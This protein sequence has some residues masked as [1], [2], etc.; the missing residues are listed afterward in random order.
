MANNRSIVQDLA[1]AKHLAALN[2]LCSQILEYENEHRTRH[3]AVAAVAEVP[4]VPHKTYTHAATTTP[5]ARAD[6]PRPGMTWCNMHEWCRHT[7]ADCR[8][9]TKRSASAPDNRPKQRRTN[10]KQSAASSAS[11]TDW[12][13]NYKSINNV[14]KTK[15]AAAESNEETGSVGAVSSTTTADAKPVPRPVILDVTSL[16]PDNASAPSKVMVDSGAERT[17]LNQNI[18]KKVGVVITPTSTQ[19][20][21][22]SGEPLTVF[23][24]GKIHI[25]LPGDNKPLPLDVLV[26]DDA[27]CD[28]IW[29]ADQMW[30]RPDGRNVSM[31]ANV[32]QPLVTR[33]G[34]LSYTINATTIHSAATVPGPHKAEQFAADAERRQN[35]LDAENNIKLSVLPPQ[36]RSSYASSIANP[37]P[38]R[39]LRGADLE[40]HK[41]V[42]ANIDPSFSTRYKRV[43]CTILQLLLFYG[44][45]FGGLKAADS[46]AFP[47]PSL[48]TPMTFALIPG[49]DPAA[50]LSGNPVRLSMADESVMN[51]K[52]EEMIDLGLLRV[53]H[54]AVALAR[55]FVVRV[56]GKE[57]RIVVAMQ[58]VNEATWPNLY[59]LPLITDLQQH[60]AKYLYK[61]TFDVW[62]AF[63]QVLL[64]DASVPLT[65][66][67]FGK[68]VCEF[69][70]VP[71]GLRQSPGHLQRVLSAALNT[72][73][74]SYS[75]RVYI[76]DIIVGAKTPEALQDALEY[77]FKKCKQY[78]IT[79]SARKSVIGAEKTVI[80]GALVG[81]GQVW[82]LTDHLTAVLNYG[83]PET[84][85]QM[86]MFLGKL[87]Q[88][89]VYIT[90]PD[91]PSMQ[92]LHSLAANNVPG[93]QKIKWTDETKKA[94]ER[95]RQMVTNT[96]STVPFNPQRQLFL[97]IDA[98]DYGFGAVLAHLDHQRQAFEVIDVVSGKWSNAQHKYTTP[99]KEITAIRC[100]S[101]RFH[102]LMYG[103]R[104][105]V[106]CDNASV[107]HIIAN[108]T[109]S[110]VPRI[111]NTAAELT[112]YYLV[113]VHLPGSL[114]AAA[115]AL[116]R[117]PAFF[118]RDATDVEEE[119]DAETASAP[120]RVESY[121][122]GAICAV[123]A[124][125]DPTGDVLAATA[126][127]GQRA[128]SSSSRT[129]IQALVERQNTDPSLALWR[130]VANGAT[131]KLYQE[132]TAVWRQAL[133]LKPQFDPAF[134]NALFVYVDGARRLVIPD[135]YREYVT[136]SV[137]GDAHLCAADTVLLARRHYY[138]PTM[139]RD[140]VLAV[141]ACEQ[142]QRVN[143]GRQ[144]APGNLGDVEGHG[145]PLR[146]TEW[147]IDTFDTGLTLGNRRVFV[148]LERFS[149]SIFSI[150]LESA[151][152]ADTLKAY[153]DA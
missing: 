50:V 46:D 91:M 141:R 21:S 137:H 62:A 83:Y 133:R 56:A 55:A 57:P 2:N 112:G 81:D 134:H 53:A 48:L 106:L 92:H 118:D 67:L 102:Y 32:G 129:M 147:E 69:M 144:R 103:R 20:R 111:R 109:S 107:V 36:L 45:I 29:G 110:P 95:A 82:P 51:E 37:P 71:M 4:D 86:R 54:G 77:L 42:A 128:A 73:T 90:K 38:L 125:P 148:A 89:A 24:R 88:L 63:Y 3:A 96:R 41:T 15:A 80:L 31:I 66:T 117:D 70:V 52:V 105:I 1:K 127:G 130:S 22:V 76:D 27:T 114:N 12:N 104:T 17:L 151:S 28:I 126:S 6:P 113:V 39:E 101:K 121:S 139:R 75:I 97:L 136:L 123:A 11:R 115:D 84:V 140:I 153:K 132:H 10:E 47:S 135:G 131:P 14:S 124:Q 43:T 34:S 61:A 78:H 116:S 99:E 87:A 23:G 64:D 150:V 145:A 35:E 8:G 16:G 60:F 122:I 100:A 33:I 142:C 119:I 85:R 19:L 79:L 94:F 18:A 120:V 98:S 13:K 59:P 30:H 68:I 9:D 146:Y 108:G 49:R 143:G 138:W 149:G 5:R 7:T 65:A 152:A 72:D 58:G 93:S 25:L 74:D 26:T 40:A 44:C